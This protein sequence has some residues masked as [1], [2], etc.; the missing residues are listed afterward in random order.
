MIVF[1]HKK[2]LARNAACCQN[3][4][5]IQPRC[6]P[7]QLMMPVVRA[8]LDADIH[9]VVVIIVVVCHIEFFAQKRKDFFLMPVDACH[10]R[11]K[12]QFFFDKRRQFRE[13][14]ALQLKK[15]TDEIPVARVRFLQKSSR[16]SFSIPQRA[17]CGGR[18]P[19]VPYSSPKAGHPR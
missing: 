8:S 16:F 17:E 13:F 1:R 18:A 9:A 5:Q 3:R 4:G 10:I 6:N 12:F 15:E 11:L 14:S 19:P 2:R 7:G